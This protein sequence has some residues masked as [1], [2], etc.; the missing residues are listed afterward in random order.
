MTATRLSPT[1]APAATPLA[2]GLPR[3]AQSMAIWTL[4]VLTWSGCEDRRLDLRNIEAM[5][6]NEYQRSAGVEV[7]RV[8]CPDKVP[9]RKG[10]RF[11][12]TVHFVPVPTMRPEA[13]QGQALARPTHESAKLVIEVEQLGGSQ[14]RWAPK[15]P[16]A[17]VKDVKNAVSGM[18][19]DKG[20]TIDNVTCSHPVFLL[21]GSATTCVG[22]GRD[23]P[24]PV[25]YT[26]SKDGKTTLRPTTFPQ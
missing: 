13:G 17:W 19:R 10:H 1:P 7:A 15:Q 5:A 4:A 20:H 24:H 3:V 12:C 14:L 21:W 25:E 16:V 9:T 8:A 23:R 11:D 26:V 6:R 22:H 18:L 2:A